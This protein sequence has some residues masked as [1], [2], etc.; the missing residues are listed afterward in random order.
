MKL[1][2]FKKILITKKLKITD[3]NK[4]LYDFSDYN[5]LK[6]YLETFIAE[7]CQ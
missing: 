7:I 6:S 5:T 2:A 3:G 1:K 4:V